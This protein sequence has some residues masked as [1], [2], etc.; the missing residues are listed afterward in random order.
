MDKEEN[1]KI[2]NVLKDLPEIKGEL[3]FGFLFLLIFLLPLSDRRRFEDLVLTCGSS[4]SD[5]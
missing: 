4:K 1:R 3:S 2:E 5:V